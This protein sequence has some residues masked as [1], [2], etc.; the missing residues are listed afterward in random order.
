[1]SADDDERLGRKCAEA[2]RI[3]WEHPVH[4]FPERTPTFLKNRWNLV[5]TQLLD[6]TNEDS[7]NWNVLRFFFKPPFYRRQ[8]LNGF[9]GG[10]EMG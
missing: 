1:L 10:V 2:P 9:Y 5:R 6:E 3:G 7:R 8:D 4:F